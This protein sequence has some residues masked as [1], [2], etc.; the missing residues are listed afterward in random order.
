MRNL[1]SKHN[2]WEDHYSRLAK[3]EQFLARSVYKLREIQRKYNLIKKG[4]KILDLGCFPGSWLLFAANLAGNNGQVVGID[5]K[6]LSKSVLSKV[7]SN[8]KTY[9]GD[10][11]SIDDELIRSVG[12]DFNIV[13]SD[14][15]PDTTGN[16][17]VDAARSFNLCQAAL[18]IAEDLLGDGGSFICKIFQGEDFKEFIDSV[19]L[20]FNKHK[21]FKPQ[22]SRKS[23]K[24][25]Y[26]VGFEKNRR[27]ICRDIANGL[28]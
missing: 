14:M 22:S 9:T 8:V 5:L 18:R 24:E 23:S 25:I 12:K 10:L 20:S 11:L 15:A 4:D 3:K 19:K 17:N 28:P 6:P 16:K 27:R 2:R 1:R 13:M 26:I 21:I 7:P